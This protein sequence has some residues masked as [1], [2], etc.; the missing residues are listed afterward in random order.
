MIE[1]G[2]MADQS[3][4]GNVY[5]PSEGIRITEGIAVNYMDYPWI[6]CF[7]VEGIEIIKDKKAQ[8]EWILEHPD[9]G[10][11]LVDEK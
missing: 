7:E 2:Y 11:S 4:L 1:K 6:S 8:R 3:E 5:Y 10:Y 9:M